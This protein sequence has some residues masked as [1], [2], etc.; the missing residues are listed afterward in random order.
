MD[1]SL[2]A[3]VSPSIADKLEEAVEQEF[4]EVGVLSNCT[5][6]PQIVSDFL[7]IKLRELLDRC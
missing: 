3:P 5:R 4:P 6:D 1:I 2:K 7:K